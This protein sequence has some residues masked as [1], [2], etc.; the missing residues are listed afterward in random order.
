MLNLFD[1]LLFNDDISQFETLYL[2]FTFKLGQPKFLKI[3]KQK[4]SFYLRISAL[5]VSKASMIKNNHCCKT[6]LSTKFG[7]LG[8]TANSETDGV[9]LGY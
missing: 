8:G 7:Y 3:L 2:N 1:W 5:M 4:L 6:K 9:S